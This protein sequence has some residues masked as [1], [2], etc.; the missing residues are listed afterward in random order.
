MKAPTARKVRNRGFEPLRYRT[1]EG[2]FTCWI[3]RET[4]TRIR[5]HFIDATSGH[6]RWLPKGELRYMSAL[7]QRHKCASPSCPGYPWKASERA[8]PCPQ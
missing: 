3:V 5:V 2:A 1:D 4:P 7:P 8:H 6:E